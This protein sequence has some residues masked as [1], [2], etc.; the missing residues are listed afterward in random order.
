MNY[1]MNQLNAGAGAVQQ[2]WSGWNSTGQCR[3]ERQQ[4]R[5]DAPQVYAQGVSQ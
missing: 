3:Q 5:R 2:I 1:N 4:Q